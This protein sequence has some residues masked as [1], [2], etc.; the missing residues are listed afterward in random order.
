MTSG[1]R[2]GWVADEFADGGGEFRGVGEGARWSSS[3]RV[4]VRASGSISARIAA[5]SRNQGRDSAP[6]SSSAGAAT[7]P[8]RRARRTRR[9]GPAAR[10]RRSRPTRA[11]PPPGRRPPTAPV[12]PLPVAVASH[13]AQEHVE[14]AGD[15]ALGHGGAGWQPA[16]EPARVNV[17]DFPDPA[18]GKAIPCGVYDLGANAGG[19]GRVQRVPGP[20]VEGRAGE[21]RGRGGPCG[22]GLP[23]PARDRNVEQG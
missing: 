22:D 10:R 4:W 6:Q 13:A 5:L 8:P 20:R 16:G 18:V 14:R 23:L 17:H 15:V 21:V 9:P 12:G 1:G 2:G 19:C 11:R 3:G 7:R